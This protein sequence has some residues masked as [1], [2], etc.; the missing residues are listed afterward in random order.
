MV[1]L[2]KLPR[3]QVISVRVTNVIR[4]GIVSLSQK[5]GQ[6][7][8]RRVTLTDVIEEGVRLLAKRER[9]KLEE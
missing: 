1:R 2:N 4:D 6:R 7:L 9:I 8:Q 5:M 3:Q